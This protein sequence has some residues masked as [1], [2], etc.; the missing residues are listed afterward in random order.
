[1]LSMDR[2]LREITAVNNELKQLRERMRCEITRH[3][4]V[5]EATHI[6]IGHALEELKRRVDRIHI[7]DTNERAL[8]KPLQER[9]LAELDKLIE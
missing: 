2:A 9:L 7:I 6:E 3:S 1:M 5:S 4:V 8:L